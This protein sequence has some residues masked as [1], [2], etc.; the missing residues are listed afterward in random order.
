MQISQAAAT[1][2]KR[3]LKKI[4]VKLWTELIWLKTRTGGGLLRTQE[5]IFGFHRGG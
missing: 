5:S 4:D 3:T 2:V 1:V